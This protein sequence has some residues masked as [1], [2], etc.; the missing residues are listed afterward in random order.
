MRNTQ[1]PSDTRK[2]NLL[3][4]LIDEQGAAQTSKLFARVLKERAKS[5]PMARTIAEHLLMGVVRAE[6]ES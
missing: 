2:A 3:A 5:D 1:I 4:R 6:A